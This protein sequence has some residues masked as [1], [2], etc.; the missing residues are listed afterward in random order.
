M[1]I[2][3]DTNEVL[4]DSIKGRKLVDWHIGDGGIHFDLDDGKVVIF[5][6]A[7]VIAVMCAENEVLH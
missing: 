5:S 2:Q 4:L 3:Q 7:F 6:G 1:N